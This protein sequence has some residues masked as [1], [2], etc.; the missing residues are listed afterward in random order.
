M[1]T[2]FHAYVYWSGKAYTFLESATF[3]GILG[4]LAAYVHDANC[5]S[6][7]IDE[8]SLETGEVLFSH[9]YPMH[10]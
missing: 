2:V 6:V 5:T 9:N 8:I 3:G 10:P 7:A 4:E 1:P